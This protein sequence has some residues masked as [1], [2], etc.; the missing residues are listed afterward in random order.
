MS[1]FQSP[2]DPVRRDPA[3]VTG[4]GVFTDQ[5]QDVWKQLADTE[6]TRRL[7]GATLTLVSPKELGDIDAKVDQIDRAM[8]LADLGLSRTVD[9]D[10]QSAD[11]FVETR[12]LQDV[13]RFQ[14]IRQTIGRISRHLFHMSGSEDGLSI[15]GAKRLDS[16]V[17]AGRFIRLTAKAVEPF[18]AC[19]AIGRLS[20]DA[21]DSLLEADNIGGISE[22]GSA[23]VLAEDNIARLQNS[24]GDLIDSGDVIGVPVETTVRSEPKSAVSK[25]RLLRSPLAFKKL[26]TPA[27]WDFSAVEFQSLK[28]DSVVV[29]SDDVSS[30]ETHK[31][32][33]PD[34]EQ[35]VLNQ[36]GPSKSDKKVVW[37]DFDGLLSG[38]VLIDRAYD[39]DD[40]E[41]FDPTDEISV[42]DD[43]DNGSDGNI[44]ELAEKMAKGVKHVRVVTARLE[45]RLDRLTRHVEDF[46]RG[47]LDSQDSPRVLVNKTL[48][49][50]DL[51]Q[52]VGEDPRLRKR[53][54]GEMSDQSEQLALLK[55][56]RLYQGIVHDVDRLESALR[57]F[58]SDTARSGRQN[59]R[60]IINDVKKMPLSQSKIKE[61]TD[62]VTLF[63]SELDELVSH[64]KQ[65][66]S[67]VLPVK[68]EIGRFDNSFLKLLKHSIMEIESH[69]IA[70]G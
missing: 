55:I 6:A 16:I 44:Q 45:N 48:A 21:M 47:T 11:A 53:L 17:E 70:E 33:R 34:I 51:I 50:I 14:K 28:N 31:D 26:E 10:R 42:N 39:D 40:W 64:V 3:I 8:G 58:D 46:V 19:D 43:G 4:K 65:L 15:S 35:P 36:S 49:R 29:A 52:R 27:H 12:L 60:D 54:L 13:S 25:R 20:P 56:D 9:S 24:T 62:S 2:M 1:Y 63:G 68:A 37:N 22:I 69:V 5:F 57:Y 59:L 61:L 7:S 30:P 41:F 66:K 32:V 38:N 67:E 23:A 18:L